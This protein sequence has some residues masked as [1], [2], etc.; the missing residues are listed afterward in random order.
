MIGVFVG[1]SID[2]ARGV[3]GS[4]TPIN[5]GDGENLQGAY[6]ADLPL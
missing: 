5:S 3:L 6:G 1:K 2:G 4:W